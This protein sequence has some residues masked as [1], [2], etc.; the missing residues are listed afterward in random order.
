VTR[1][2][3][4]PSAFVLDQL[5]LGALPSDASAAIRAHVTA[6]LRCQGD[7]DAASASRAR[8]TEVVLPRTVGSIQKRKAR[9]QRGIWFLV[10]GLAIPVAAAAAVAFYVHARSTT[11]PAPAP[12]EPELSIKGGPA[13][14]VVARHDHKVF[15]LR[16]GTALAP[17]DELRFVV[18]SGGLPYLLV[19][20]IDGAGKTS[21]YFPFGGKESARLTER[22]VELPG[23]VVLDQAPGPERVFAL[24]SR[25]PIATKDVEPALA[26]LGARGYG[27]IRTERKLPIAADAQ[28][29]FLLEKLTP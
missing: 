6:C 26:A 29:T 19:A 8:F 23:S 17:G 20:S 13:F 18:T 1:A 28:A 4:H 24:F 3:A 5:A 25:A 10:P 22:R 16:D 11:T 21:V 7:V 9:P 14:R 27:A 12:E 2:D 15:P